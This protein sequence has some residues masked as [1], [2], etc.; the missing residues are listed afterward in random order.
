MALRFRFALLCLSLF[1]ACN[2]SKSLVKDKAALDAYVAIARD[3]PGYFELSDATPYIPIGLNMIAPGRSTREGEEQGLAEM[4]GWM[5]ALSE[6][7]GNYVRIWLSNAFWDIEHQQAGVY[8]ESKAQRIDRFLSMA[9]KY[10]LRVKMTVE[11]FRALTPEESSQSWALKSVYH[12]SKGGPLDSVSQYITTQ[13]GHSLLLKKLDFY[14]QR[15]GDDP[16]IFG[17]ELWN[18]MNAMQLPKDRAFF[19][20]NEKM[21]VELKKRFPKNLAMQSLGSFDN[22]R[23]RETYR[24]MMD[25][26]GNEVA[27]VHRYLDLGA[28]MEIC[29]GPV[30]ILT[31]DAVRELLGYRNKKPVILAETGA[32][33]PRHTGPSQ[34]YRLDTAGVILHDA[35]FAPF[36][37]GAAGAG[38]IWHWDQYVAE[39]NLWHHFNRFAQVVDRLNPVKE[40]LA[41][42]YYE[43]DDLRIYLLKGKETFLMWCRDKQ[44]PWE[45]EL[46]NGIEARTLKRSVLPEQALNIPALK[47]QALQTFDPWKNEWRFLEP[48][49]GQIVLPDFRRSIIV[50]G[51]LQ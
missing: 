31:A 11:H 25:M 13:E 12:T 38:M 44:S 30:D 17:W 34:Y 18:E 4:E 41:P 33:E 3:Q 29:H 43:N 22:L 10:G 47:S 21:L 51:Q 26:P 40:Q 14:Q 49:N 28:P 20:W 15:Y 37:S 39:N 1:T 50:K 7:G 32:V 2:P 36:F 35:L 6:N 24:E 16:I 23:V 45:S 5:K 48:V 9:R 27:Q 8:D 46:K 19:A 42:F